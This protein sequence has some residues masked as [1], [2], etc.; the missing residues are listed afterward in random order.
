MLFFN[1][2]KLRGKRRLFTLSGPQNTFRVWLFRRLKN[3]PAPYL[4]VLDKTFKVTVG[5]SMT[6]RFFRAPGL[7]TK[8]FENFYLSFNKQHILIK[9]F[10]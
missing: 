3:L 4:F 5:I 7:R 10:N 9:K 6:E 2:L 8:L 1:V